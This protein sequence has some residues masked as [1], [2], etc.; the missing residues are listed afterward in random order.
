MARVL[1]R[2]GG[3]TEGTHPFS[4]VAVRDGRV[5]DRL[6]PP[7]ATT[8]RSAAKPFQLRESLAVLGDPTL[9][10]PAL[11]VGA[12][13]H[14]AEPW[15]VAQVR[16]VLAHFGLDEQGLRCAGHAP[17]N[18]AAAYDVVR[19]GVPFS[20]I[21]NNC[22]GKHSFMLA[23]TRA[24]GWDLDYRPPAHP[25]QVGI[26]RRVT[27]LCGAEPGEGTDGCGVPTFVLP[28]AA[29]GRAWEALALAMA[30]QGDPVLGRI[31]AA[32]AA[33]PELVSGTGRLDLAVTRGAQEP[34]VIKIGALGLHCV[35]LPARRL[36]II[37]KVHS[38]VEAALAL[39]TETAL[40]TFAP[41]AYARQP[42]WDW[43]VVRNVAGVPV[44]DWVVTL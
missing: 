9:P 5:V 1:Q 11:A 36:A 38:G 32:M 28:L 16:H 7:L 30:G 2:R 26:R 8:W 3:H 25:L 39:A 34:L 37:V 31:G 24:A 33:H 4:A 21:H 43:H 41:G 14:T 17:L 40:E 10:L 42:D 12:A 18:V 6:G 15:H 23:A 20:D 13:S 29:F 19:S 22:S 35:A 44:G 27:A